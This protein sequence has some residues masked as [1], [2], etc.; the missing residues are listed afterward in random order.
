MIVNDKFKYKDLTKSIKKKADI[1]KGDSVFLTTN[2][3][4]IGTPLTKKKIKLNLH[5]NGY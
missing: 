5:L 2:I 3:A 1:K 4:L